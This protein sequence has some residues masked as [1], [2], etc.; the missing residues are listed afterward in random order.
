MILEK[1]VLVRLVVYWFSLSKITRLIINET[2]KKIM[3]FIWSGNQEMSKFHLVKW[4][5]ITRPIVKG[6]CGLK[7]MFKFS[8]AL[9]DR[10]LWLE[11]TRG[12][13]WTSVIQMK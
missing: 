11:I 5:V 13:V 1:S 2:R 9:R 4:D 6:G 3:D 12:S 10:S 7:N 8:L